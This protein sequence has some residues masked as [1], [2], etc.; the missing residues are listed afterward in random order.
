MENCLVGSHGMAACEEL[1]AISLLL[2]V[3]HNQASNL[4]ELSNFTEEDK[5]LA[6]ER[7]IYGF[8]H[9]GLSCRGSFEY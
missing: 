9:L 6:A 8:S 2:N 3:P 4:T 5:G 1:K 7:N